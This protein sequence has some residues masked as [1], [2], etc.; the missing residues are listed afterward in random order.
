MGLAV[1]KNIKNYQ[2]FVIEYTDFSVLKNGKQEGNYNK[3]PY[4]YSLDSPI[5][6]SYFINIKR[7][8]VLF[9]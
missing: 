5:A 8:T 3:W 6:I 1:W 7:N 9:G 4:Y 2:R